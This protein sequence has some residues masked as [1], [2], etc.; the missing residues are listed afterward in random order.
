[1]STKQL[2][3]EFIRENPNI[4]DFYGNQ[5]VQNLHEMYQNVYE[6]GMDIERVLTNPSLGG[7]TDHSGGSFYT[8]CRALKLYGIWLNKRNKL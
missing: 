6:K 1:M 4:S 3:I 5:L 2:Q 7:T 8:V